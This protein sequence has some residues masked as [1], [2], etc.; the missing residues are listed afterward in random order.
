MWANWAKVEPAKVE[1]AK[2]ESAPKVSKVA[3]DDEPMTTEPRPHTAPARPHTA[4]AP[5]N[6]KPEQASTPAAAKPPSGDQAA[7]PSWQSFLGYVFAG[8]AKKTAPKQEQEKEVQKEVQQ[9]VEDPL[10]ESMQRQLQETQSQPLEEKKRI[11]RDLQ[12]QLHPDKNVDNA[13]AAKHAF[14]ELMLQRNSYL[15]ESCSAK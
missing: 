15:A 9:K 5:S 12:R 11:F 7:D 10:V 1:P 2:V 4:P 8:K 14:Q 6:A 13:A 3:N